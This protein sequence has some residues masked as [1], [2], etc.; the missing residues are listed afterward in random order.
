MPHKEGP[1]MKCFFCD[2]CSSCGGSG[3]VQQAST[4]TTT[5]QPG[6]PAMAL[7]VGGMCVG[8]VPGGPQQVTQVTTVS[9]AQAPCGACGAK[10]WK[11]TSSMT[12]K[13]GPN[14]KCFFCDDCAVCKGTGVIRATMGMMYIQ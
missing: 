11:H 9:G 3:Q 4:T 8:M 12:H 13:K 14:E 5:V 10:G 6:A 2:S 7:N 1:N